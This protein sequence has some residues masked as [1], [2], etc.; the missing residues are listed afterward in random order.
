MCDRKQII[1]GPPMIDGRAE[2]HTCTIFDNISAK[3]AA[4]D[5]TRNDVIKA[6]IW[7]P[8]RSDFPAFNPD[9]GEYFPGD[10]PSRSAVR[11]DLL[12]DVRVDVQVLACQAL[13]SNGQ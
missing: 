8:G 4:P 10:P 1:D 13:A 3:L 5:R 9:R 12:V 2:D 6:M 7:G 11:S